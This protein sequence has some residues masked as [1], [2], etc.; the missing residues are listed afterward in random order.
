MR[1]TRGWK[2]F[3]CAVLFAV[4][5]CRP[6]DY[7]DDWPAPASSGSRATGGCPDLR[8]DYSGASDYLPQLLN[9]GRK[10]NSPSAWHPH[11]A[12]V[13]Q[14]TDGSW[15][16]MRLGLSGEALPKFREWVLK[17]R[18]QSAAPMANE[19]VEAR[20][21]EIYSCSG[22]WLHIALPGEKYPVTLGRDR[23]G[24]LIFSN[25][26]E[27]E[28]SFGWGNA[29]ISLGMRPRTA[30]SRWLRRDPE[31]DRLRY[32]PDQDVVIRRE[33]RI[34]ANGKVAYR[35]NS[36]YL[37]PI[38]L[39]I[40][41]GSTIDLPQARVWSFPRNSVLP[42]ETTC[43][44]GWSQLATGVGFQREISLSPTAPS[45]YR[46]EWFALSNLDNAPAVINIPDARN[47][48]MTPEW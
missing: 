37:E 48:P 20:R 31:R 36:F 29:T 24:N 3:G 26:A 46:I 38:C 9:T 21:D 8:G 6:A 10:T 1:C 39:R 12:H 7:P 41:S 2:L 30:W 19:Y 23:D 16:G 25:T 40:I 27:N 32:A 18:G 33:S 15:L 47:L 45:P 11:D 44:V 42:A 43:P 5:G 14:A 28:A 35:F 34:R 17:Y 4:T 22:G 13:T